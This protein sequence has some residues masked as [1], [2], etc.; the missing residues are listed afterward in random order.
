ME[1]CSLRVVKNRRETST[2]APPGIGMLRC[3]PIRLRPSATMASAIEWPKVGAEIGRGDMAERRRAC[4]RARASTTSARPLRARSPGRRGQ[5][6]DELLATRPAY[7]AGK[8][9]L[10]DEVRFSFPIAQPRPRS[11]GVTVPSVS[12]PTMMKPF[13]ARRHASPRCRRRAADAS[14]LAPDR[15][16]DRAAVVG[17]TLTSKPISP[18][19]LT[20][21]RRVGTPQMRASRTRHV[22]E[23]AAARSTPSTSGASSL[24]RAGPSWQS[25]PIA[26]WSR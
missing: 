9:A 19:K 3:A 1:P 18:V 2:D 7:R 22:R 4:R 26:P 13:S 25:S 5:K 14:R 16:P 6:A 23:G 15:L 24:A 10:A 17:G 20:R 21:K 12:W 11:S 8:R